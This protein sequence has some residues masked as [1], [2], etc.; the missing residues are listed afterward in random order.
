MT[1]KPTTNN[2][3]L[4]DEDDVNVEIT[5]EKDI[6][7]FVLIDDDDDEDVYFDEWDF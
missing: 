4:D 3:L 1:N 6:K 7:D 5:N 2:H